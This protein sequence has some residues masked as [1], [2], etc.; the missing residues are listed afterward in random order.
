MAWHSASFLVSGYVALSFVLLKF[1]PFCRSPTEKKIEK[2]LDFSPFFDT[3]AG[4]AGRSQS[5]VYPR[6]FRP[7]YVVF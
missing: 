7:S 3:P 2:K 4:S 6:H 5:F 1:G